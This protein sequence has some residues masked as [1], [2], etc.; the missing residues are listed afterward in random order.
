M[1]I[2]TVSCWALQM[3]VFIFI[4]IICFDNIVQGPSD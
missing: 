3:G 4:G 2:Q 1:K